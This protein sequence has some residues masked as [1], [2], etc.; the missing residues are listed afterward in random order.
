MRRWKQTVVDMVLQRRHR[1]T[2][3]GHHH[4]EGADGARLIFHQRMD[5]SQPG[6][7]VPGLLLRHHVVRSPCCRLN[8]RHHPPGV[9][10]RGGEGVEAH[11]HVLSQR[12]QDLHVEWRQGGQAE[13][14]DPTEAPESVG[15]RF[16]TAPQRGQEV[17]GPPGRVDGVGPRHHR[18]PQ[19]SLP[20]RVLSGCL[21]HARW[22]PDCSRLTLPMQ[23]EIW[24]AEKVAVE[25]RPDAPRQ[26]HDPARLPCRTDPC[27]QRLELRPVQQLGQHRR[28]APGQPL[29]VEGAARA[30]AIQLRH[31]PPQEIG[32]LLREREPRVGPHAESHAQLQLQPAGHALALD[33]DALAVGRVALGCLDL[34]RQGRQQPLGV[35]GEEDVEAGGGVGHGGDSVSRAGVGGQGAPGANRWAAPGSA[36]PQLGESRKRWVVTRSSHRASDVA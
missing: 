19:R 5:R 16:I 26:G 7:E 31:V 11:R 15:D 8:G 2:M 10:R 9:R 4:L 35:G 17:R 22:K 1:R 14:R 30:W 32:Q 27:A 13:H 34:A 33:H 12:R 23:N 36:E 20:G 25:H 3:Q 29:P 24:P 21:G 6:Q 28:H 18:S